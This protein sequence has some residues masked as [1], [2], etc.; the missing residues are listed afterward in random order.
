MDQDFN[1][2]ISEA[3]V[4]SCTFLTLTIYVSSNVQERTKSYYLHS[5]QIF[6]EKSRVTYKIRNFLCCFWRSKHF[7]LFSC[8]AMKDNCTHC[9]TSKHEDYSQSPSTETFFTKIHGYESGREINFMSA[10]SFLTSYYLAAPHVPILQNDS[11]TPWKHKN[12]L[13]LQREI[14]KAEE[15]G[16]LCRTMKIKIQ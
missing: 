13:P 1:T 4:V 6:H 10:R 9:Y 8:L 15:P 2:F 5:C 7:P 12:S 3:S 14:Q 16:L 11:T